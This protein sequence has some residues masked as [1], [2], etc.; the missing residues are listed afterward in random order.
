MAFVN[1]PAPRPARSLRPES[2]GPRIGRPFQKGNPGKK[3]GTLAKRTIAGIE[4]ARALSGDAVATLS[5]LVTSRSPRIAFEASKLVLAYSWGAPR[6]MIELSGGFSDLSK[7][8]SLALQA[9]RERR[10]LE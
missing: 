7:E 10:A 2:H 1:E 3:R 8:L 6:Q 4:A 5:R 9:V